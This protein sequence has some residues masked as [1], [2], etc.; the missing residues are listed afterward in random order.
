MIKQIMISC[1]KTNEKSRMLKQN[2]DLVQ[3]IKAKINDA[4]AK[5]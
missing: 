1:K 3:E 2:V 4:K 5:S